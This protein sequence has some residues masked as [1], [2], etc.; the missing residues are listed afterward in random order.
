MRQ[1]PELHHC[2]VEES[3]FF[4]FAIDSHGRREYGLPSQCGAYWRRLAGGW[5][6]RSAEVGSIGDIF[7]TGFLT[8]GALSRAYEKD[9]ERE[10]S[11]PWQ[12]DAGK[13]LEDHR[14]LFDVLTRH[15]FA[16][17]RCEFRAQRRLR[18]VSN[19]RNETFHTRFV[20]H[21][22]T[23]R[24]RPAPDCPCFFAVGEG[25]VEGMNFNLNGLA[26][27]IDELKESWRNRRPVGL[28]GSLPVILQAGDG[29]IF[30]HEILGHALEA[31]HVARQ[32]SPFTPADLSRQIM[33]TNLTLRTRDERDPFFREMAVDDEGEAVETDTLV[34]NGVLK[35]LIGDS[36][37]HEILQ[38]PGV[39]F[40]RAEDF[41]QAPLPRAAS[42]YLQ[43]GTIP[44]EDLIRSTR[45]GLLA[46]EF[47]EGR[48]ILHRGSFLFH[49]A[50]VR[51]I[52]NGRLGAPAGP[53]LVSG[54]IRDTL[55][56]ISAVGDDFRMDR[57][58]SYCRKNGQTMNVRVGQPSV[59][60]ERMNVMADGHH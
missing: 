17:W 10:E 23:V 29:A 14:F 22:L 40:A 45:R 51:W 5:D 19:R 7:R 15:E 42:L 18:W 60:I 56:E 53:V 46:R 44:A 57:G 43:P 52:E 36:F 8:P 39:G 21:S 34:E 2:R 12:W 37:H 3:R 24:F 20:H 1:M 54:N 16:E 35:S 47:G 49:I 28:S 58:I 26:G 11:L 9:R 48:A 31:D 25:N 59:K 50:D 38:L 32:M 41:A 33:P 13:L 6:S 4:R 30:F 55:S 27:R